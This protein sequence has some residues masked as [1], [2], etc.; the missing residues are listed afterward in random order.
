MSYK[1]FTK[2]NTRKGHI[3]VTG[4]LNH[5]NFSRSMKFDVLSRCVIDRLRKLFNYP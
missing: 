2:V 5:D 1:P 4:P 3:D